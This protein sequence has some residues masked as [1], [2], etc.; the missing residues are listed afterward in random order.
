MGH[1]NDL[2][3]RL[4]RFEG[5]AVSEWVPGVCLRA[6]ANWRQTAQVAVSICT[7]SVSARV[8]TGVVNASRF[9]AWALAI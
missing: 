1:I 5:S 6:G 8:H 2:I 9:V 4:T 3:F 7:A